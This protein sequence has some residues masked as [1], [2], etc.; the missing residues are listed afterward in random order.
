MIARAN[1]KDILLVLNQ[2]PYIYYLVRY[3]NNKIWALIDTGGKIDVIIAT[4]IANLDPKICHINVKAKKINDFTLE[5]FNMVM[6]N[7]QV[8]DK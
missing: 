8:E 5:S 3:K 4:N 7:L 2:T 1:I 6:T